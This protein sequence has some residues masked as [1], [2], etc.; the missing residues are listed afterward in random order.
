MVAVGGRTGRPPRRRDLEVKR[1][2][3][4]RAGIPEY[5]IVDPEGQRVTVPVLEGAAYRERGVFGP[6]ETATSATLAGL[7]VAV[8]ELFAAG[9]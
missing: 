9:A 4:A 7:T 6:G 2:E 1:E 8:G 3:Y 5:G